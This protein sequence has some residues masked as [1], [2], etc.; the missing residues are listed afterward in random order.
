MQFQKN[1]QGY[2]QPK[3]SHSQKVSYPQEGNENCYAIEE[4][5]Q[6]FNA[7]NKTILNTLKKY[8]FKGDFLDI[9]GGNGFQLRYLQNIYFKKNGIKSA[10][11]EPGEQGC[12][13]AASRGVQNV[14]C[15][16]FQDFPFQEFNIGAVGLFDVL[17]HIED[18]ETFLKQIAEFLPKGGRIYITVPA[19][20]CLW[21]AEDDYAGHF[22]RFNLKETKRIAHAT[23]L[24]I[25]HQSYFFSY[26]VPFVWLL[27]VLPEKLG[28]KPTYEEIWQKEQNYHQSSKGLNTVLNAFHGVE[29]GLSNMGIQPFWGSS[30]LI[31]LEK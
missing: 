9:G 13:N 1:N 26:Y 20:Q 11:C 2:F 10:L 30:R 17:E 27:R 6:W 15:C 5:S 18:D 22:R 21:S 4:N 23:Q 3:E 31:I 25:I 8:P 14:Y 7:R 24:K 28:K 16:T 19:M 12:A 29:L